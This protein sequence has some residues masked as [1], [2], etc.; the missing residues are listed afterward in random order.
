MTELK[1]I[2]MENLEEIVGGQDGK[3]GLWE[4]PWKTVMNLKTG[5]LAIRTQ[6]AYDDSNIIGELYNGESVQITGNGTDNG[7]IWVWSPKVN[8][9]GWVNSSFIG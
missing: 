6:P 9:S 5:Y 3:V 7:Y 8:K 1:K 4:G 2:D